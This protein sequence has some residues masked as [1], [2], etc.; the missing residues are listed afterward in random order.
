MGYQCKT[1]HMTTKDLK[2]MESHLEEHPAGYMPVDASNISLGFI[3]SQEDSKSPGA[4]LESA[5]FKQSDY[6][7][8]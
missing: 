3:S 7:T 4:I 8:P 5:L 6:L 2:E 1:C